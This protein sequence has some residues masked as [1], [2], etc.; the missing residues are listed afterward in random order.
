MIQAEKLW[1]RYAGRN[2]PTLCNIDLAVEPGEL[3]LVSGPTGCGKSSLLGCLNGILQHETSAEVGGE[4]HVAG[5]NVR[6]LPLPELCRLV[7]TVFQNPE[8]QICTATAETEVAFGLE[9][10]GLDR[11]TMRRRIDKA[12]Q[13]VG[14]ENYRHQAAATLSGGQ[15]QRLA[16]ACALALEP[17]VL[18][19]DEPI[20][21]LDPQA[22]QDILEVIA[23]LKAAHELAVVLVEHRIEETIALADRVVLLDR[24]QKVLDLPREGVL[25]D[26]KPLRRL[27]LS[28]PLLPELFERLGRTERPL[29][30]Q[31]APRLAFAAVAGPAVAVTGE[32]ICRVSELC[33][34][35]TKQS[36]PVIDRLDLTLCR[37]ERIALM[38]A[39]GS[40]KS[41]L[42]HLLAGLLRPD[43][44]AVQWQREVRRPVGLVMQA[45]D[46]MLFCETVRQELAFAPQ[47]AGLPPDRQQEVVAAV[48]K[49][50]DVESL[51][52][53]PPFA[54]SRGQRLRTAV[55]SVL[56]MR[57]EVLLLDEPT[58]GQDR[59]QIER[60]MGG[61]EHQFE[62]LVF[63]T[64]DVQ[65]TARHAT[66][67]LVLHQGRLLAD[68]VPAEVLFD[69]RVL[70]TAG[71]RRTSVQEY[72]IQQG[73]RALDVDSLVEMAGK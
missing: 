17:K 36:P 42:L 48:A 23:R 12:L 67:V 57:P 21:Q 26:L 24:G 9:N 5:H 44:G 56:S 40:G 11:P 61:L 22:A 37:R 6:R 50:M 18:L 66:R 28:V 32:P 55:G 70:Q 39:N 73:V 7:G 49:Q 10:Q 19:L 62:L 35:Y 34:A 20:S 65:T 69:D 31:E 68:G 71:L 8:S 14:L 43:R 13:T 25:A 3:V 52:D 72:A 1:L 30:P 46:L 60:I 33:F 15:K 64:H 45:P 16:I 27:G 2:E 53:E 58:T 51:A 38:G 29:R 59:E 47:H 54:L 63:C 41:T 4:V